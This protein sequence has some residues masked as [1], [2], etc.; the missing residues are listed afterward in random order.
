[1]TQ[2]DILKEVRKQMGMNQNDF[3]DYFGI[4]H[5]T[6][7]DWEREERQMPDYLL[8]LILYKLEMEKNITG[9]TDQVPNKD[10]MVAPE[11]RKG[12]GTKNG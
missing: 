2:R 4:P 1:M 12:S 5:R 11:K 7:Q 9:F 3:A 6:M 10:E 8:R